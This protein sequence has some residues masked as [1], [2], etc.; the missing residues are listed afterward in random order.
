MQL[1]SNTRPL[2][3]HSARSAKVIGRREA[4]G[5]AGQGRLPRDRRSGNQ[6]Q[7]EN[8]NRL[9][10]D[11]SDTNCWGLRHVFVVANRSRSGSAERRWCRASFVVS[12]VASLG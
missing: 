4:R 2:M 12:V 1:A 3:P 5:A 8:G 9:P 11:D 6:N 7:P 10:G